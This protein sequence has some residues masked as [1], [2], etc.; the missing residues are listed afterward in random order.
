MHMGRW[1]SNDQ[2][3]ETNANTAL[4]AQRRIDTFGQ[5]PEEFVSYE[6]K[7]DYCKLQGTSI[8]R[9]HN[10]FNTVYFI[11]CALGALGARAR[12]TDFP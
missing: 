12:V 3:S 6:T 7:F 8:S 9:V 1:R 5:R 2:R 10:T 11:I 4:S